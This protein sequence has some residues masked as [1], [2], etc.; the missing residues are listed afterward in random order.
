MLH[1][2]IIIVAGPDQGALGHV[3]SIGGGIEGMNGDRGDGAEVLED[4]LSLSLGEG[5]AGRIHA[6]FFFFQLIVFVKHVPKDENQ[7]FTGRADHQG[8]NGA[9]ISFQLGL[10]GQRIASVGLL[11]S[12]KQDFLF[13]FYMGE[14]TNAEPGIGGFLD[15]AGNGGGLVEKGFDLAVVIGHEGMKGVRG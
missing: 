3:Q 9:M 15:M 13:H 2:L 4:F 14:Q 11:G 5:L 10:Q 8:G 1:Q 12:E 6:S 7:G